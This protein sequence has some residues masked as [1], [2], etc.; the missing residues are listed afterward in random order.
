M[1]K[2]TKTEFLYLTKRLTVTCD[3]QSG[4]NQSDGGAKVLQS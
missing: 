4:Y 1:K 2:K 3:V